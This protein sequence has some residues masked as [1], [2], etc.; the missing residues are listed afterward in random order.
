CHAVT[1]RFT[2]TAEDF[3]CLACGTPVRGDGYTN[4]CPRCL[5]SRHVDVNPGDRA[6]DCAG[7]MRPVAVEVR[8]GRTILLHRCEA[9]GHQR[10][11]RISPADDLEAVMRLSAQ[12]GVD[13]AGS[14]PDHAA[15]RAP[16]GGRERPGRRERARPR[17]LYE[18]AGY[19]RQLHEG[20]GYECS[21][22]EGA[23]RGN[24]P[25]RRHPNRD[26]PGPAG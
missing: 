10:R 14:V 24:R 13:H 3:R 11:N 17:Q 25:D 20:S 9:C 18:G 15:R 5:W 12:G 7:S 6:A 1:R 26:S 2:R 16:R 4:H 21:G 19:E 22:Y 23:G 8:A